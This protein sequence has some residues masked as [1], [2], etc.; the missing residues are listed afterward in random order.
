METTGLLHCTNCASEEQPLASD[1]RDDEYSRVRIRYISSPG[2]RHMPCAFLPW[3]RDHRA[4]QKQTIVHIGFP[5][6][7]AVMRWGARASNALP[8]PSRA[9]RR[10]AR[11]IRAVALEFWVNGLKSRVHATETRVGSLVGL[12][13]LGVY[14]ALITPHGPLSLMR[15]NIDRAQM[16]LP[17]IDSR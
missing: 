17:R 12:F 4:T 9:C 11:S 8:R 16:C 14:V 10:T 13:E 2:T 3:R 5:K 15:F 7:P 6:L 1:F